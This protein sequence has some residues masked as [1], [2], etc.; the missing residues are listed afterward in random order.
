MGSIEMIILEG[1]DASGKSTLLSHLAQK[2]RLT[3]TRSFGKPQSSNDIE[4][5]HKWLRFCPFPLILD[6]H[7]A[8]SELIY[9]PVIRNHTHGSFSFAQSVANSTFLVFCCPPIEVVQ[10][11]LMNNSQMSGVPEKIVQLYQSYQSLMDSLIPSFV[12]DYTDRHQ[13]PLLEERVYDYLASV[14]RNI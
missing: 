7:P 11:G 1:C 10:S 9:G 2:F 4:D 12:Y 13:L 8:I 5:Y 6:R 3:I 14:K